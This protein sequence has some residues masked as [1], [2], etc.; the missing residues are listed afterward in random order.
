MSNQEQKVEQLTSDLYY[1]L[2]E[3]HLKLKDEYN[4][5]KSDNKK[6][7]RQLLVY[8]NL[9]IKPNSQLIKIYNSAI[10]LC[11]KKIHKH[12][13]RNKTFCNTITKDIETLLITDGNINA[14]LKDDNNR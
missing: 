7:I 5:L 14:L 13:Y 12:L 8:K 2:M 4:Q 10:N 6:L 1:D 11:V 9:G 3:K